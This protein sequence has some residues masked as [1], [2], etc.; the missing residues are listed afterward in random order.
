MI[1]AVFMLC[2]VTGD[3]CD[4]HEIPFATLR[5]CRA[6]LDT[7]AIEVRGDGARMIL[8]MCVKYYEK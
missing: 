2:W 6:Y 3:P 8:G 4:R 7:K 5:E 1:A